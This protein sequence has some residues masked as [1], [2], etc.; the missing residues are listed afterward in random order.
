MTGVP[1]LGDP[2]H[3]GVLPFRN[4]PHR[5]NCS[6]DSLSSPEIFIVQHPGSALPAYLITFA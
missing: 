1:C 5:Y 3:K 2:D 4:K 6:V